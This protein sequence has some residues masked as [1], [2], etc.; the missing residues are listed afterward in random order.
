MSQYKKLIRTIWS[1]LTTTMVFFREKCY[2][3]GTWANLSQWNC[4]TREPLLSPTNCQQEIG[5]NQSAITI[6]SFQTRTFRQINTLVYS[7]VNLYVVVLIG[8]TITTN[9]GINWN[10]SSCKTHK[11][12][13]ARQLAIYIA[14]QR[15][16]TRDHRE[17]TPTPERRIWIR[18]LRILWNYYDASICKMTDV[19]KW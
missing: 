10:I 2:C 12:R 4:R 11:L 8:D 5:S 19:V 7:N 16:P 3:F 13:E 15:R 9:E 1:S 14:W 18:V 6:N 17:R